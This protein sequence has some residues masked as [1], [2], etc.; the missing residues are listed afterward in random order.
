[1]WKLNSDLEINHPSPRASQ[2]AKVGIQ[3][4]IQELQ[5]MEVQ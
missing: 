5:E 4:P 3:L 2:V 1:M